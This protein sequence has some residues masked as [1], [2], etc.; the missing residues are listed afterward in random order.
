MTS[1]FEQAFE[2]FC[3]AVAQGKL[4]DARNAQEMCWEA[5]GS[6]HQAVAPL[7]KSAL[8]AVDVST[9]FV[10]Q[11]AVCYVSLATLSQSLDPLAGRL[12]ARH[13]L[14]AVLAAPNLPLTMAGAVSAGFRRVG[15]GVPRDA[16][17]G[18][19]RAIQD[20]HVRRALHYALRIAATDGVSALHGLGLELA[21]QQL[22][23][24]GRRIVTQDALLRLS[25]ALSDKGQE[26]LAI[27]LLTVDNLLA[28]GFPG[29]PKP[30][31]R[32]T[33][34]ETGVFQLAVERPDHGMALLSTIAACLRARDEV[35]EE[36]YAHGLAQVEY[37][38]H[39]AQPMPT[40]MFE[41]GD[42][43]G[44]AYRAIWASKNEAEAEA[45][46][47]SYLRAR[48]PTHEFFADLTLFCSLAN[49]HWPDPD[50]FIVL[51][52]AFDLCRFA[53]LGKV[54]VSLANAAAL[55]A[56]RFGRLYVRQWGLRPLA[57]SAL[58]T[59]VRERVC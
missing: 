27:A 36:V 39:R 59:K 57:D 9:H 24:T 51:A 54:S 30:Y 3:E 31:S 52:A 17:E 10:G 38:A 8:C 6:L 44:G 11:L 34:A 37:M 49:T 7:L 13:F 25:D 2:Q 42:H 26:S 43:T 53:D 40:G 28:P 23:T 46:A 15:R 20:G 56:L 19:A 21:L 12:A 18:F 32:P 29:M 41:F 55:Q 14:D 58:E 4:E 1:Q 5:G 35:P 45:A 33:M 47:R 48:G 16:F 22:D 50:V